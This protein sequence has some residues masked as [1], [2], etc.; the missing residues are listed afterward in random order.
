MTYIVQRKDRFYVVAY[1][2]L[3][4]LTGKEHR[5]WHPIGH[6]RSEAESVA[7]RIDR[8]C[9]RAG[10]APSRGGPVHLGE[11]LTDTWLPLK[12][13]HVRATTGTPGSSTATSTRPSAK[14]PCDDFGPIA[15]AGSTTGSPR[16]AGVT[17]SV[18]QPRR[19]TRSK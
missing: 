9:D 15:S 11:F 12:R 17:G 1:D 18:L 16:T 3:D 14:F 2:G 5:R 6:D 8:D 13:R 19:C 7:A 10:A 4:P